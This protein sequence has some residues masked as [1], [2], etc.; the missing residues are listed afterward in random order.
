M[1]GSTLFCEHRGLPETQSHV[2]K[3]RERSCLFC[4]L[5]LVTSPELLPAAMDQSTASGNGDMG[6]PDS[7]RQEGSSTGGLARSGSDPIS[8]NNDGPVVATSSV[9]ESSAFHASWSN[10]S[11]E[12]FL[13]PATLGLQSARSARNLVVERPEAVARVASHS[14]ISSFGGGDIDGVPSMIRDAARITDWQT[15]KDLCERHPEAASFV[16]SDGWTALHH[17]CNRRCPHADVVEALI[18]AYPDALSMEEDKGW[19]PLHYACRFKANKDVVRLLLHKYPDRGHP[20]VSTSDRQGRTPL[21]Y[22]VRY[23]APPGVVPLLL[24]VDASAVL[25]EDQNADSPLALVWDAWAEKLDGQ[26]TLR[27]LLEIEGGAEEISSAE[28]AKIVASR[29]ESQSKL[30]LRWNKV[31]MFLK[32]AFGFTVDGDTKIEE[33]AREE[34][35]DSPSVPRCRKWR[36]LH[37]TAAIKCH[38]SLFLLAFT[39]HPEQAF[40][41]DENDL[42]LPKRIRD[43]FGS[44]SQLSVLHLAASSKANGEAGRVVVTELLRA[45]PDSS[46]SVASDGS[47]PLHRVVQNQRK[48]HW[49]FDGAQDICNANVRAAHIPDLHGQLPLHRA[50]ASIVHQENSTTALQTRSIICNLLEVHQDGAAHADNRG[51][52]PLHIVAQNGEIWDEEVQAIYDAFPQAARTRAGVALGNQ[53]PLHMASSNPCAKASLFQRFV[54]LNPR[55]AS[56]ADR[57][58]RLP[59]HLACESGRDWQSVSAIH[60]AHPEGIRQAEQNSRHWTPLQI[61]SASPSAGAE[62]IANL[63]QLHPE[64]A[65]VTDSRGRQ[66]LHLACLS[67]KSWEGGLRALFEAAPDSL[68]CPDECGL[69]PFH[70]ASFRYCASSKTNTSEAFDRRIGRRSSAIQLAQQSAKEADDAKKIEILFHLLKADPTVI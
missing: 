12:D 69:L 31:S 68:R 51:C 41:N 43:I 50:A 60:E 61:A 39:L 22:A 1:V 65:T 38:P 37:A 52:L 47:L 57:Q 18:G 9:L 19:T 58:G 70:I 49:T 55:G 14:R 21:Y 23:D 34:K 10:S 45:N 5:L 40:E 63:A 27:R 42:L 30:L 16:G 44:P 32:A 29:L 25:E 20:S 3:R 66:A 33:D 67:G 11:G 35:K 15:V 26:R 4:I 59:L 2:A 48:A 8:A 24:E 56:Q 17:A 64:S 53:L 36:I 46:N 7:R 6:S 54:E 13:G 62:L 28:R